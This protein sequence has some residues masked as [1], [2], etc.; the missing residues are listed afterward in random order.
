MRRLRLLEKLRVPL[1]LFPSVAL[2]VILFGGGLI[3]GIGQSFGYFPVI[4]LTD[5]TPQYYLDVL[6]DSPLF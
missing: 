6:S 1:M 4:G 2:L 5:F 3:V